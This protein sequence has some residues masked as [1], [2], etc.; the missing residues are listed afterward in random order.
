M[1]VVLARKGFVRLVNLST[2]HPIAEPNA[3]LRFINRKTRQPVTIYLNSKGNFPRRTMVTADTGDILDIYGF[4]GRWIKVG[5][6]HIPP[7]MPTGLPKIAPFRGIEVAFRVAPVR[8]RVFAGRPRACDVVQ[9]ELSNCH[10]AAAAAA[11]AHSRPEA[12][13]LN[14][15]GRFYEVTVFSGGQGR[16]ILVDR[17]LYHRPS[18]EPI[19]GQNGLMRRT[20]P[21]WWP[22]LEKAYAVALGGYNVLDL[23]GTPHGALHMITGLP[24]R[25]RILAT[26]CEQKHWRELAFV[27]STSS[28]V[29]ATT[30]ARTPRGSG[31][32]KEHCYTVLGCRE[33]QTRRWIKL[34]NPWG[35]MT[36]PGVR[37]WRDG[38]FEMPWLSFVRQFSY[39]SFLDTRR[40]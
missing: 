34:R 35:E 2:M 31:I 38:V 25:H 30:P 9:G 1:G 16:H 13:M 3:K 7:P 24:P 12:L 20:R 29:V 39:L 22:I 37:R 21:A 33:H 14:A 32:V 4:C 28:P 23:G 11:V 36:P 8:G 18:G 10:L 15:R 26:D 6:I 40:A 5:R 27:L 19:F 17:K